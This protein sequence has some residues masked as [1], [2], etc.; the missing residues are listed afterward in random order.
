MVFS[1]LENLVGANKAQEGGQRMVN[2]VAGQ[3]TDRTP[4]CELHRL[5]SD[6]QPIIHRDIFISSSRYLHI[7]IAISSYLYPIVN[8]SYLT[9]LR[10]YEDVII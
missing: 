4:H 10:I 3:V 1:R 5:L 6:V 7:F 2:Q 9:V 8:M